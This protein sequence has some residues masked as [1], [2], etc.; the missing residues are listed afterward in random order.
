MLPALDHDAIDAFRRSVRGQVLTPGD[1]GY[2]AARQVWNAMIDRH[3]ALIARC[4]GVPTSSPRS[5]LLVRT[6]SW[7]PSVVVG[8]TSPAMPSATAGWSLISRR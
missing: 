6:I 7:S 2:D 8:T 3:P 4:A 1:E 5:L